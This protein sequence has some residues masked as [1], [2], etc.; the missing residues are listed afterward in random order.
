MGGGLLVFE[1]KLNFKKQL[2]LEKIDMAA[3]QYD[4]FQLLFVSLKH[5]KKKPSSLRLI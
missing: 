3:F 2:G 1:A 5:D 4:F